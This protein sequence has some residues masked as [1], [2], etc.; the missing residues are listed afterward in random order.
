M[1]LPKS[2]KKRLD[3]WFF[4]KNP[5]R[6]AGRQRRRLVWFFK[7]SLVQNLVGK[8]FVVF[9]PLYIWFLLLSLNDY[10]TKPSDTFSFTC[11]FYVKNIVTYHDLS[12]VTFWLPSSNYYQLK[13]SKHWLLWARKCNKSGSQNLFRPCIFQWPHQRRIEN[14]VKHLRWSVLQK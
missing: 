2:N 12:N 9:Y 7:M 10:Q 4:M 13:S 1:W 8:G 11:Y 3:L 14:A 5:G 6:G